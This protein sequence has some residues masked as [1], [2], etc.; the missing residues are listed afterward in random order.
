[1]SSSSSFGLFVLAISVSFASAD[2]TWDEATE[3]DISND[4]TNP[5]QV[6]SF[7]SGNLTVVGSVR[8]SSGDTRDYVTFTV[9]KGASLVAMRLVSYL[10]G[11]T[12]AN[13]NTGY[14]MIDDGNTSVIPSNSTAS[15]F[16]GG[17]HLNRT[18]FSSASVNML[19]RLSQ[20]VQGGTGFSLPL[21]PGAYTV[22]VQQTGSQLS[23]YEIR[24]EFETVTTPCPADYNED[25][26]VNGADLGIFLGAWGSAP[27]KS[28]L[29]G[30]GQCTG[31][32]L[33]VLL[34]FWGEC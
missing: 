17:S 23:D 4:P 7:D 15:Q 34:G 1:M 27:C 22:D 3:G 30:D 14:V 8:A 13:G 33:G 25:G 18:R 24:F 26:F 28:D 6:G 16:L 20:G 19:D 2:V 5:T 32:D 31:A 10:D 12:G 29:T 11:V 21:G 9:D